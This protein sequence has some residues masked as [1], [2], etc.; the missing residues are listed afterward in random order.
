MT[1]VTATN[2]NATPQLTSAQRLSGDLDMFLTLMTTQLKNQDPLDPIKSSEYT[3]QLATYSQ[4]EQSIQ[5][6]SKLEAILS[7]LSSQSLNAAAS[8]VGMNVTTSQSVATL[9][10]GGARWSYEVPASAVSTKLSVIDSAGRVVLETN[11]ATAKG[12]HEF[13]WTGG[14][15]AGAEAPDGPYT[16][17][18]VAVS[19]TGAEQPL[20]ATVSGEV[21][22]AV[23]ANGKLELMVG[24]TKVGIGDIRSVQRSAG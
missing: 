19:S 6:T 15:T 24:A 5:Q 7:Q 11:G 23:M 17:K 4:V 21:T 20:P 10:P 18:V 16:L 13:A 3:Q 14:T 1:S 8:Y 2:A 22:S 12:T 9:G